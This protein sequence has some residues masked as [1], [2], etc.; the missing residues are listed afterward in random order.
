MSHPAVSNSLSAR[1]GAEEPYWAADPNQPRTLVWTGDQS[2]VVLAELIKAF[3]HYYA[4]VSRRPRSTAARFRELMQHWKEEVPQ[5]SPVTEMVT[6]TAY[7]QI[8][9]LGWDAVPL[10]LRELER[11]PDHWFWALRAITG[12]DPVPPHHRGRII[13]MANDWIQ[14]GRERDLI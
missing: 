8:I 10:L 2:R 4:P 6:H 7:Q 5:V 9:G 13:E 3:Q 11:E 12:I 14:W 1:L